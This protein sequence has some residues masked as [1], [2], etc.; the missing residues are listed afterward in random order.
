MQYGTPVP[1]GKHN[2]SLEGVTYPWFSVSGNCF[3]VLY[4]LHEFAASSV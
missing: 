2:S 4:K 3:E 1:Q